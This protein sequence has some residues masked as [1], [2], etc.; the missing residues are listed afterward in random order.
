MVL[1]K[2]KG[3]FRGQIRLSISGGEVLMAG[4]IW[5]DAGLSESISSHGL[6][7]LRWVFLLRSGD[8]IWQLVIMEDDMDIHAFGST[9]LHSGKKL[10]TDGKWGSS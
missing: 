10:Q 6:Q 1:R 7:S 4:G 2:E 9:S 3:K 5:F 8:G